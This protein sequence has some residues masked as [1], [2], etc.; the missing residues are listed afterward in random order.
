MGGLET[1]PQILFPLRDI[2]EPYHLRISRVINEATFTKNRDID[3]RSVAKFLGPFS[4]SFDLE[5]CERLLY[6]RTI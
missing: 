5:R 4:L 1:S 2:Y 3:V 6:G